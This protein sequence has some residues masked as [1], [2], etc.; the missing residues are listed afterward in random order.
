MLFRSKE[1]A[2][3][4]RAY[5]TAKPDAPDAAQLRKLESDWRAK[6]KEPR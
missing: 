2:D 5:L 3:E 1:A 6:A 4:I